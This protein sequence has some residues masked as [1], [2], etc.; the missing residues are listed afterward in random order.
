MA[1]TVKA[2]IDPLTKEMLDSA[3]NCTH[4]LHYAVSGGQQPLKADVMIYIMDQ[5]IITSAPVLTVQNQLLWK[6]AFKDFIQ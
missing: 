6:C 4:R 2:T 1:S 5:V 3:I